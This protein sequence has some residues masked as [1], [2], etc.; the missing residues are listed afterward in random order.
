MKK[1]LIIQTG[2]TFS[3]ITQAYGDF[4][5]FILNQLSIG[6]PDV[7]IVSV[8]ETKTLP[9]CS[10]VKGV[11]ITGSH[12]MVTSKEDWSV[13]TEG[14]LRT[15]AG[16]SIPV[17]GICYGH[18]LIA[19]AFGGKV[20]YHPRGKEVGTTSIELTP[21]GKN[22][23]LL[24]CMPP[25]FPGHVTHAQTVL[26]L[27]E[28]SVLLATNAFEPHHAYVI[29]GHIW[30]VQFHPEFTAAITKSYV[31]EQG[32]SLKQEGYDVDSI[33]NSVLEH[34]YGKI[35]LKRFLELVNKNES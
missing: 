27:P 7:D 33:R 22:D 31:A 25:V 19:E 20:G 15:L 28:R 6:R 34:E 8:F 13:Y 17:L 23:V 4:A 21:A 32:Q 10:R 2:K 14:W 26:E 12:A 5:D 24:G 1:L 16:T 18:Q 29:D 3:S 11:I 35:L 30:G 9:E